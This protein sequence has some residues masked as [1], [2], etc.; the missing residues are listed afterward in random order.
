[1]IRSVIETRQTEKNDDYEVCEDLLSEKIV[2]GANIQSEEHTI[3]EE[4]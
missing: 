1:M 2:A 4:R 3:Q